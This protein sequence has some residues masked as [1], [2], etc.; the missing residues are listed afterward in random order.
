MKLAIFF[1]ATLTISLPHL[2]QQPFA[3]H[4]HTQKQSLA[5]DHTKVVTKQSFNKKRTSSPTTQKF[6]HNK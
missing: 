6:A 4:T 2:L 1:L 5:F 3:T